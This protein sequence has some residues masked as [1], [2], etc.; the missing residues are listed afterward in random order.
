MRSKFPR[1]PEVPGFKVNQ[2]DILTTV[3]F[4]RPID[5]EAARAGMI[6]MH[7][8]WGG[9]L[10]RDD[11]GSSYEYVK[12][13][14]N[15]TWTWPSTFGGYELYEVLR[16]QGAPFAL[17]RPP[18]EHG[19]LWA[20]HTLLL[21]IAEVFLPGSSRFLDVTLL[22]ALAAICFCVAAVQISKRPRPKR[23]TDALV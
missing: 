12:G 2:G 9:G 15:P 13:A 20:I 23:R 6:R 5:D 3:G 1:V 21:A 22:T 8:G 7:V 4:H 10:I 19:V 14:Q 18:E 16:A 11:G 17:Q